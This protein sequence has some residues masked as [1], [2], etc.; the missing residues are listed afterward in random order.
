[1]YNTAVDLQAWGRYDQG[2]GAGGIF[3]LLQVLD[4]WG[5]MVGTSDK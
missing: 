1:M 5:H 3:Y 4:H 2:M